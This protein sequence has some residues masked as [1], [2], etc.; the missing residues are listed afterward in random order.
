M[1]LH[2][3]HGRWWTIVSPPSGAFLN[4]HK[5]C[6]PGALPT[7]LPELTYHLWYTGLPLVC[8]V[9]QGPGVLTA[10][11]PITEVLT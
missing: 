7:L 1:I 10:T 2:L 4:C 3:L 8:L 6:I 5:G 9:T 11:V